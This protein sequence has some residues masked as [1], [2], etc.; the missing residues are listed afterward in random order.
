[1]NDGNGLIVNANCA[2]MPRM[3][4][5]IYCHTAPN[6]KKYVGVT[7]N[8]MAQR[9][10]RHVSDA[11]A[12]SDYTFHRAIRKHG[13]ENF[14]SEVLDVLTTEAGA[15]RAEQLWIKELDSK[16]TGYND[17][18]GG[19]GVLNPSAEAREKLRIANTG[20]KASPEARAKMSASAKGVKESDETRARKSAAFK[21][22]KRPDQAVRNIKVWTGRKHSPET[23]AKMAA[24][25]VGVKHTAERNAAKSVISKAVWARRKERLCQETSRET[26]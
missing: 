23:L 17:T 12:G 14:T 25:K 2:I 8:T 26:K 4:Y 22:R 18:D 24:S 9:W 10:K 6:G 11:M 19:R 5:E 20:K 15:L 21:G 1:M 7:K 16:N 13:A 3:R